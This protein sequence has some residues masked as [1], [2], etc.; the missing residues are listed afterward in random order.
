MSNNFFS[1]SEEHYNKNKAI[2]I[3]SCNPGAL[4]LSFSQKADMIQFSAG[5]EDLRLALTL[6]KTNPAYCLIL[7]PSLVN[8]SPIPQIHS[9][10]RIRGIGGKFSNLKY[11]LSFLKS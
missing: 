3:N 10:E 1:I 9:A 8:F 6:I 5:F 7:I 2:S 11:F 4:L